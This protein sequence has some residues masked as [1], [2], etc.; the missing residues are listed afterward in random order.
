[1]SQFTAPLLVTPLNDGK[2]WV[3]ITDDFKY[4]IGYEGSG[5]SVDVPLGMISDFASVPQPIWWLAA[6]WGTHGH[7]AVIHDAGYYLQDRPRREYD[8][9]F[10]EAMGVLEVGRLKRRLMY[11]A[12]RWFGSPAWSANASRNRERPGWKI[13]DPTT[14]G[15]S[16]AGTVDPVSSDSVSTVHDRANAVGVQ[17]VR[18]AVHAARRQ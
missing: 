10:L 6:P 15:L 11:L 1:M 7:A 2:S 17:E 16:P 8:R 5:D 4:D 3:I 12:V 18:E 13:V 14:L 9:I